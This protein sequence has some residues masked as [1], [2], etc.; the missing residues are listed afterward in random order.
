M[1][2]STI[3]GVYS[4]INKPLI[5]NMP[6]YA[7][8]EKKMNKSIGFILTDLTKRRTPIILMNTPQS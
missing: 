7:S 1:Q 8:I 6:K 3:I 2:I 4:Q 5:I